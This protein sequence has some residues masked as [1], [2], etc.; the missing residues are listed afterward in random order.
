[1]LTATATQ[2]V[3][4]RLADAL[5]RK[6]LLVGCLIIFVAATAW[7]ALATS[8]ESFIAARAACGVGAGGC[9]TL[10]AII[11]SDLVPIEYL[12]SPV[13]TFSKR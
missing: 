5:G 10:G 1:M 9:M 7:C 3:L 6:P 13:I 11:M 4:G 8:I 2:P 12:H